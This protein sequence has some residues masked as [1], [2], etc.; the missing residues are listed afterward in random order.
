MTV[1]TSEPALKS[2]GR[3]LR[4]L[5]KAARL[6]QAHLVARAGISRDT[7]S[8][9]ENG[10]SAETALVQRIAD[11]LGYQLTVERKPVRAADMR[12]KYAHLHAQDAE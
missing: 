7:L 5:R 11:V 1:S 2:M 4:D 8:R 9:V 10:E 3:S 6:T 12:R